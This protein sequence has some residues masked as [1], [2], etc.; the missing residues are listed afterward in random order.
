MPESTATWRGW[1]FFF[2]THLSLIEPDILLV[3]RE[4]GLG[5]PQLE[6]LNA[7]EPGGFAVR[8]VDHPQVGWVVVRQSLV[9]LDIEEAAKAE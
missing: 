5:R 1:T 9:G 3:G 6:A 8:E 2:R 4:M 7:V